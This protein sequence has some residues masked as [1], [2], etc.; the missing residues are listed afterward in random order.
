MD[1]ALL[2][3]D[4]STI[5]ES[6]RFHGLDSSEYGARDYDDADRRLLPLVVIVDE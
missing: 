5:R 2:T 4:S 1:R 6:K 3:A